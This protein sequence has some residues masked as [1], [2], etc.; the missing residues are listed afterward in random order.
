MRGG[1]RETIRPDLVRG[2]AV[3]GDP[4]CA[5]DDAVDLAAAHQVRGGRVGDHRVRDAELLE[6]PGRQPRALQQR[7]RLVDPDVRE[8]AVLP[9]RAQRADRRAVAA[10]REAARVAVRQGLRAG[11]EERG[12]VGTHAPAAIDLGLVQRARPLRRGSSR[13]C[14][15]AQTRLTAV[16]LDSARTR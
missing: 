1:H 12:G 6:L 10:G 5:R 4:V 2:V 7:P 3:G 13:I 16:G 9:R 8:Q 15:S 14:S 11:P